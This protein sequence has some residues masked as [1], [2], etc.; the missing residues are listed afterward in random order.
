[1]TRKEFIESYAARC[2]LKAPFAAI[3]IL[4]VGGRVMIALPCACE[5]QCEGWA[6]VS[7]EGVLPQLGMYAPASLTAAYHET[8][9]ASG[10]R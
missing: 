9:A 4:D 7:I 5:N 3:G 2:G 1:M 6:M 8:V 10:G